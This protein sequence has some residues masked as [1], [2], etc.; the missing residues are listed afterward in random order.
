MTPRGFIFDLDGTLVDSYTPIAESLNYALNR[1]GI[2]A[3]PEA[4][5][6][7]MVGHGL[8]ELIRETAGEKNLREGVRLF[9]EN[10]RNVYL[11]KTSLLPGVGKTLEALHRRGAAM[12]VATN[13]PAFFSEKILEHLGLS[14]YMEIVLGP[15]KVEH[16]KPHPEMIERILARF[17]LGGDAVLYV[18]DMVIDIE[19]ARRA[20]LA[21]C[22][23]PGGS[24]SRGELRAAKPDYFV[25]KFS[26]I[27]DLRL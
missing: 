13:K 5:V 22:V 23:V 4:R 3:I 26:E 9:R 1:F 17:R 16:P 2:E 6:R 25:E 11:E 20:G 7:R 14:G 8:E 15:E 19:T 12:A 27:A 18:G 10:Y 21:V 24:S